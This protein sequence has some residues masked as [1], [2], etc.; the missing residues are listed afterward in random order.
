MALRKRKIPV[1]IALNQVDTMGPWNKKINLPTEETEKEIV[2]RI[3]S[4]IS[5][6]SKGVSIISKDQIE[7]YSAIRAYRLHEVISKLA[8]FAKPG[9]IIEDHPVEI[10]DKK[11]A[12][13]MPEE[14]R[15]ALN[16][17][18]KAI[19][20]ELEEHTMP[21]LIS[22][23]ISKLSPD[24]GQKVMDHYKEVKEKP[25]R[26]GVIGKTGA[27]K[28]TTVNN[29]FQAE[30][31]TSRTVVGT[32]EAQYED[33]RLPDG[34]TLT[35]VDMPGYGRTLQEDE[36]YK[37]IYLQELPKC[38]IILII[39]QADSGDLKDDQQMLKYIEEWSRAGLI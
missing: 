14:V 17:R 29:L 12:P 16:E 6:L 20:K 33:Y 22:K 19:D 2:R 26:I 28:T 30:F 8:A 18:I 3:K 24:E 34:G 13:E 9:V 4:I 7:Y 25:V 39:I 32:T 38:D 37:K 23:L 21:S 1:V 31:V 10:T 11:I 5:E 27:G 15:Q 35:I 36:S